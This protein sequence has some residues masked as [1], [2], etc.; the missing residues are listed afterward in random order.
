V[1]KLKLILL[2]CLSVMVISA[3]GSAS[4]SAILWLVADKPLFEKPSGGSDAAKTEL[5]AALPEEGGYTLTS[6]FKGGG[7]IVLSC[8]TFGEILGSIMETTLNG[9]LDEAPSNLTWKQCGI[10]EP[11]TCKT[12]AE[13]KLEP[14]DSE[15]FPDEVAGAEEIFDEWTSLA[16]EGVFT[17][18]P[19]TG[20]SAEGSYR[21]TG[22]ICALVLE[23]E[24]AA[25]AKLMEFRTDPLPAAEE[26]CL[27]RF[28]TAEATLTGE[29]EFKLDGAKAGSTWAVD[30]E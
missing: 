13:I 25:V 20:C 2:C 5:V 19:F 29:S 11:A 10:D 14:L 17:T 3:I 26:S 7:K 22:S 6:T 9:P 27:L 21:I 28:A 15:L 18:I 12:T 4:A 16:A 24:V 1:S 8:K 23:P 30:K